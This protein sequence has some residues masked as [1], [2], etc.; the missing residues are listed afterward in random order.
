MSAKRSGQTSTRLCKYPKLEPVEELLT[1]FFAGKN[2]KKPSMDLHSLFDVSIEAFDSVVKNLAMA[3]VISL[4]LAAGFQKRMCFHCLKVCDGFAEEYFSYLVTLPPLEDAYLIKVLN[5]C[6]EH[7]K[8]IKIKESLYYPRSEKY[9]LLMEEKN[10]LEGK[11][12][13]N[14]LIKYQMLPEHLF[15]KMWDFEFIP[16][17]EEPFSL[18]NEFILLHQK[19]PNSMMEKVYE[20]VNA[21]YPLHIV[22]QIKAYAQKDSSIIKY[23]LLDMPATREFI[24]FLKLGVPKNRAVNLEFSFERNLFYFICKHIKTAKQLCHLLKYGSYLK[25]LVKKYGFNYQDASLSIEL[26]IKATQRSTVTKARK[27]ILASRKWSPAELLEIFLSRRHE[28]ENWFW[29]VSCILK[30]QL[31]KIDNL[32]EWSIFTPYMPGVFEHNL[33]SNLLKLNSNLWNCQTFWTINLHEEFKF[34]R[35]DLIDEL[36]DEKELHAGYGQA[37]TK[38]VFTFPGPID[39]GWVNKNKNKWADAE[40]YVSKILYYKHIYSTR[41][42]RV[43]KRLPENLKADPDMLQIQREDRDSYIYTKIVNNMEH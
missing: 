38:L 10:L 31:K 23:P 21:K 1:E 4:L 22:D 2:L 29:C 39:W 27:H 26:L 17:N 20:H 14:A 18:Y 41:M 42:E 25:S 16:S 15:R 6:L 32:G 37:I 12:F 9:L 24:R 8:N 5:Y 43:W 35:T 33:N 3:D 28:T 34:Q 40:N 13:Q 11:E 30:Y 19:V 7:K 36:E